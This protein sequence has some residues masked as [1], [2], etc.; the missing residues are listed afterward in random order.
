MQHIRCSP[1]HRYLHAYRS[2]STSQ[3]PQ[4]FL[5][6]ILEVSFTIYQVSSL[7]CARIGSLPGNR[8]FKFK[9]SVRIY[10]IPHFEGRSICSTSKDNRSLACS[11][12]IFTP[13]PWETTKSMHQCATRESPGARTRPSFQSTTPTPSLYSLKCHQKQGKPSYRFFSDRY[14]SSSPNPCF[15]QKRSPKIQ[16]KILI[17]RKYTRTMVGHGGGVDAS[18]NL[19]Q[20]SKYFLGSSVT[21]PSRFLRMHQSIFFSSL[22]VHEYI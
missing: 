21:T 8:K 7:N 1:V 2:F 22:T 13:K 20:T 18:L 16:V 3:K 4:V 9:M 15:N 11:C 17:L 19:A 10:I 5:Y 14:T 12:G 6:Y